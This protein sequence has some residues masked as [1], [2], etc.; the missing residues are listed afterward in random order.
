MMDLDER[1]KEVAQLRLPGK[2]NISEIE[3]F[4][5]PPAES[6]ESRLALGGL[7]GDFAR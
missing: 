7:F 1:A 6:E 5:G 3:F 4:I 2:G